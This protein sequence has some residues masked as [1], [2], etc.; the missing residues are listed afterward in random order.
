MTMCAATAAGFAEGAAEFEKEAGINDSA[1][2]ELDDVAASAGMIAL[3]Y[4]IMGILGLIGGILG[5]SKLGKGEPAQM[6]G[7]LMLGGV[8]AAAALTLA[9]G[10]DV[11][12]M[13]TLGG[14]ILFA[15]AGGL[16]LKAKPQGAA[17]AQPMD[18][19]MP[20]PQA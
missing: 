15:I 12:G 4:A 17:A 5:F 11:V 14:G 8:G 1:S 19:G 2:S 6:P 7:G 16:A 3:G 18:A 13:I 20:P 10:G 9:A